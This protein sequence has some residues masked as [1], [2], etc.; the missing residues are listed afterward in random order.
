MVDGVELASLGVDRGQA[1]PGGAR[2]GR[3]GERAVEDVKTNAFL[4]IERG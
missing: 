3:L 1:W 4:F 2:A